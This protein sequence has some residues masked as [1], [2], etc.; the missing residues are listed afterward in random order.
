M[1]NK[2]SQ[3]AWFPVHKWKQTENPPTCLMWRGIAK[4]KSTQLRENEPSLHAS[5]SSVTNPGATSLIL[6]V[7]VLAKTKKM[8]HKVFSR[9]HIYRGPLKTS[10][11]L[12]SFQ[13]KISSAVVCG[14][15]LKK[16]NREVES[17]TRLTLSEESAEQRAQQH[18]THSHRS[19]RVPPTTTKNKNNSERVALFCR[20]RDSDAAAQLQSE[21]SDS[22]GCD[23]VSSA[24]A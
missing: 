16:K 12:V 8:Y 18:H 15:N 6:T 3:A 19:H 9:C 1:T 13:I 5:T 23:G 20:M 21:R 14:F 4:L 11:A 7:I 2:C 10:A 24:A 17:K 22:E